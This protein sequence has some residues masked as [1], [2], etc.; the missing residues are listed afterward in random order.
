MKSA[1]VAISTDPGL[2]AYCRS[3]RQRLWTL[4]TPYAE[5][6]TNAATQTVK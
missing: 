1:G 2:V 3:V 6:V 4:A 5:Y